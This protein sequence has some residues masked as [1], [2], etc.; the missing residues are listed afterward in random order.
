MIRFLHVAF[1]LHILVETPAALNFFLNPSEEL[2]LVTPSPSAEAVVR[3]YALLLLCSN[4]IALVFLLRHIDKA[5]RHVGFALGFYHLGPSLRAMSRL[6]RNETALGLSLGGPVVHLVAHMAC[7]A[8][9]T[10]GLFPW[11]AR[12]KR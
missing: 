12:N 4:I 6:V 7:L 5:S 1:G 10:T 8:A 2:Q 9:L 3:Q 11:L